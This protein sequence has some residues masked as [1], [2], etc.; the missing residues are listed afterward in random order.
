MFAVVCV[1]L[2]YTWVWC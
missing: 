2:H 1:W